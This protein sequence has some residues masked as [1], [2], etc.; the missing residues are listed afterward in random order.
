MDHF[1]D[2]VSQHMVEKN[3]LYPWSTMLPYDKS[4]RESSLSWYKRVLEAI[5][6]IHFSCK[7]G[8]S[9]FFA[10]ITLNTW[11][12]FRQLSVSSGP[13]ADAHSGDLCPFTFHR[14][15]LTVAS[16]LWRTVSCCSCQSGKSHKPQYNMAQRGH[17]RKGT[18]TLLVGM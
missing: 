11:S 6:Y 14:G 7:W 8:C 17:G 12:W 16:A 10:L 15:W 4:T 9:C 3:D 13:T 1:C 18:L 2:T 5:A